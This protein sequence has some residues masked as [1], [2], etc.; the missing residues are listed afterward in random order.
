[1]M[2][3]IINGIKPAY[4][5]KPVTAGRIV[6]A[7]AACV[8]LGGCGFHLAGSGRLPTSMQTT[9]LESTEPRSEFH[10]SISEALRRRGLEVVDSRAEAGARLIISEDSTGQRVLSVTARNI[11]REY[12]VYYTI[13]FALEA[14]GESLIEPE[15]LIARRSYT[16][17]ETEV[18]GKER[19]E[20]ILR[21]ALA[22]DLARQVVRRIEALTVAQ[23]PG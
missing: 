15:V 12:E 18:L 11:P 9:Y 14:D 19:E 16:Y 13:T 1:M 8:T 6:V 5:N 4:V 3:G 22:E 10:S 7:V 20:T 23:A 21:Q 17:D 2:L